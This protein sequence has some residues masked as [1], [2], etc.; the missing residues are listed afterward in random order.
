DGLAGSQVAN[1][2][3]PFCCTTDGGEQIIPWPGGLPASITM[4]ASPSQQRQERRL[5]SARIIAI[6]DPALTA[7]R[8]NT[9]MLRCVQRWKTAIPGCGHCGYWLCGRG[10]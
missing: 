4:L 3:R 10:S 5:V 6:D 7:L 8:V 2:R 9:P 1:G